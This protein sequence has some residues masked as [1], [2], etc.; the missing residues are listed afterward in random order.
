MPWPHVDIVSTFQLSSQD[1]Y[2]KNS[3][4]AQFVVASL[5]LQYGW[6]VYVEGQVSP[7]YEIELL[8]GFQ[9]TCKTKTIL[10]V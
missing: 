1:Q 5:K 8:S 2:I 3:Q 9:L 7:H 4:S 10:K 6:Y